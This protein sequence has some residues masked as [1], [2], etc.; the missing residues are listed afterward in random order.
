MTMYLDNGYLDFA[1]I[2]NS[3]LPYWFV[4][5]ARG[6][7][8]KTYGSLKYAK[9]HD[10]KILYMRRTQ[11]QADISS[12][13]VFSPYKSINRDD[14]CNIQMKP[15][16]KYNS[17]IAECDDEGKPVREL[18]YTCAL[19][20]ISNIRSIDASDIDV[21]IYDEFIPEPHEKPIKQE[22][23]ALFNAL[24]TIG[25]NRELYGKRPLKLIALSNSNDVACPIY[26]ELG[27]VGVVRRMQDRKL[28]LWQQPA[29]GIS[30][31]IPQDPPLKGR[32]AESS[33]YKMTRGSEFSSMALENQWLNNDFGQVGSRPLTEY[34]AL[35]NVGKL[36]ICKHKSNKTY[37][38]TMH[39]MGCKHTYN[40]DR[41]ELA[42]FRAV[43]PW[44][45]A[46]YMGRAIM[47]EDEQCELLLRQYINT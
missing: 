17:L 16:T 3:N 11:A 20:T 15:V 47:F 28:D 38:V 8:G 34:K 5:G 6:I 27:V 10:Y 26:Q 31:L 23:A 21:V 36:Y 22:A 4:N 43:Y 9:D 33:L 19:S 41:I 32:K 7:V 2:Y 30:I 45:K 25:R 18:G 1:P 24:E 35:V 44:I 29:R 12:N 42:R 40:D 39:K 37:Y 46:A 14:G 13:P